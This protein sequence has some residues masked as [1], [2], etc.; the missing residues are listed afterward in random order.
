MGEVRIVISGAPYPEPRWGGT[1]QWSEHHVYLRHPGGGKDSRHSDGK[2]YLTSTGSTREVQERIPTSD[3]SR[4][5]VNFIELSPDSTAPPVLRGSVK[6]SDFVVDT[7]SLGPT[8]RFA[9]EIVENSRLDGVRRAWEANS[10]V[11]SVQ[12]SMDKG[13]GQSLLIAFA[14]LSR[15][16]PSTGAV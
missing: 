13:L 1:V 6:E 9:V 3:V 2:T 15:T 7:A 8:P 5:L 4:E 14:S 12:T 11:S 10:T 16:A